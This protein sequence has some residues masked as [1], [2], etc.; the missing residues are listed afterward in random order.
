MTL[1][2]PDALQRWRLL[3]GE[4]AES[5]LGGLSAEAAAAD[6]ALNWLYGRDPDRAQRGERP[7][8]GGSEA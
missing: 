1:T 4:P 7:S 3:L 8:K 6:A 2:I 5:T